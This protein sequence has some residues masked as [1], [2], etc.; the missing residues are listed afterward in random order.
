MVNGPWEDLPLWDPHALID[1]VPA[2]VLYEAVLDLA[3]WTDLDHVAEGGWMACPPSASSASAC[4]RNK[5]PK[6]L[7][8]SACL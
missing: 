8:K 1:L 2:K 3:S 7:S 6:P 5:R 4:D